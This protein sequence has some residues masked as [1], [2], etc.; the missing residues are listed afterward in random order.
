MAVKSR[1]DLAEPAPVFAIQSALSDRPGW[2][3]ELIIDGTVPEYAQTINPTQIRASLEEALDLQEGEHSAAA[4]L[5]LWSATEGALRFLADRENVEMESLDP[6]YV[7]TQL[8][9]LG[10]LG[11]QQ[12]RTLDDAMRLRNRAA[13]GFQVSVTPQDLTGLVSLLND[14]LNEVEVQA[15]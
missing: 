13:H 14:L 8:Y 5:L 2:R 4:L 11:L 9:T 1:W 7:I 3:F 6:G 15:A 10:L 12:Y